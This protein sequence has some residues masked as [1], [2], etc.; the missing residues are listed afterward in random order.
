MA[1]AGFSRVLWRGAP[2]RPVL[3]KDEKKII[4]VIVCEERV[5]FFFIVPSTSVGVELLIEHVSRN[6][7]DVS[8]S[9]SGAHTPF[10]HCLPSSVSRN[11]R[12]QLGR[13][14]NPPT[15]MFHIW[16]AEG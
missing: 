9:R 10:L 6:F 7:Y 15:L 12:H 8:A 16:L 5:T 1:S 14:L 13:P 2:A 11:Y 3:S 4:F